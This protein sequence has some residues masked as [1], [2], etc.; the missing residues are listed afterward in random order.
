MDPGSSSKIPEETKARPRPGPWPPRIEPFVHNNDHNPRDLKS[1]AKRTGF[2]PNF[3]GETVVSTVGEVEMER[4]ADEVDLEEGI[5]RR[6]AR[7]PPK[8]EIEPML[9]RRRNIGVESK[10]IEIGSGNG[11]LRADEKD[12]RR[13]GVETGVGIKEERK[14][15]EVNA[16]V[17]A[18]GNRNRNRNANVGVAAIAPVASGDEESKKKDA[19]KFDGEVEIDMFSESPE[20]ENPPLNRSPRLKSRLT[21]KPGYGTR[22]PLVQGSSFVYLAPALVVINSEEFRNLSENK[23][24]HI[25]RELQGA[26]IIGSVFQTI[27]GYSGL[28]ALF[29]RLINPVVVAPTVAAVGLAFFSYGFP[30]AGTCA[31]IS[32]PLIILV[33][34]FTLYLRRIS[35]FGH[36]IFLVYAVPLSV[37]IVWAY[38]FFLTTGGAYNYKGCNSNIPNSNILLDSCKRHVDTMRHCRTDASNAWRTAAWVRVPYPFQWGAPSFHFKTSILMIIASIVASVDSVGTYHASSLLVNLRPPTPGVVSRGIGL[39]GI[40]SILA[41]LWGTGI[42]S[43]TLTENMHTLE[44]TKMGS[45]KALVAGAAFLIFISFV[46][47]V[48][49]LLASIPLALAAAVLC[50]TWGLIVA[51]GLSTM[52]YTQTASSRNIIIVGFTMFISLSIPAFFQ[53]YQPNT[54]LILP[55]YFIPYA[56]AS[57]GPIHI[58]NAGLNYALNGLLSLN[59]VVALLVAFVLDNTV[60]GTK[61]ERGVYI[62]SN[63]RSPDLDPASLEPYLLPKQISCFFRWAKCVGL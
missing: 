3:S 53:Q 19:Q 41:G 37:A 16:N 33:L 39:E 15:E 2:N 21:D 43:T 52:Q 23:F 14:P 17:N 10:G 49:A 4:P 1:W 61:Q 55:S 29:L 38:A 20:L 46:G 12:K 62:W 40:S 28:M 30:Q 45:R 24:R 25:M 11:G 13:V 42:G 18:N 6:R 5:E 31:E 35:I 36:H 22:L 57:D 48:G 7:S 32:V 44:V 56:A 54:S 9:G 59:M 63:P 58:G 47:K 60:P 8:V 50:F 51:L 27:L 34:I 26:I